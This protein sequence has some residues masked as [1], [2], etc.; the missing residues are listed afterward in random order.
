MSQKVM[1]VQGMPQILL[2]FGLTICSL[3]ILL[4]ASPAW[5]SYGGAS[6]LGAGAVNSLLMAV[7]V[8]TQV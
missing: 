7:T 8:L 1:S 3:S 5:A 2:T 6:Y 4:P